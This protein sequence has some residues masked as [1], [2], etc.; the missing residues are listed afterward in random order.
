MIY[1]GFWQ[2]DL[3]TMSEKLELLKTEINVAL[4]M[5]KSWGAQE[6]QQIYHEISKEVLFSATIIRKIVEEENDFF[7]NAKRYNKSAWKAAEDPD[8]TG[9]VYS[10][11]ALQVPTIKFPISNVEDDFAVF[12]GD[13][14]IED[15]DLT[16]GKKETLLLK[17]ISN[18]IIH[19]YIWN[20]GDTCVDRK[21]SGFFVSSD[22]D[23]SKFVNV[24]LLLMIAGG[25]GN[26]IDRI[27]LKYVVDFIEPLFVD[28]AV[29]RQA[30]LASQRRL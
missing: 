11:Y 22:F 26:I 23:K 2:Y 21:V 13:Y 30:G 17:D 20:L 19:S 28:F 5:G 9:D 8:I 27:R 18:I 10:L 3:I 7:A 16:I 6:V 4:S 24:C 1:D 14:C 25:I 12:W 15:Y 29:F